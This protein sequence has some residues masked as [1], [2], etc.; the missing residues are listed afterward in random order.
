MSSAVNPAADEVL[1]KMENISTQFGDH[2]IHA[3]ISL[4]VYRGEVLG[5]VGGSG[6]GKTTLMREMILLQ[7][8]SK[9]HIE[10]FGQALTEQDYNNSKT[11]RQRSGVMFQ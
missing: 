7:R 10:L 9:G 8:P 4:D 1:V 11:F 2:V 3:D 5:I 6:S